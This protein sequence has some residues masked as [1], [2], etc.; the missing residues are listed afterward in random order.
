MAPQKPMSAL[1]PKTSADTIDLESESRG[2]AHSPAVA[3]LCCG[4]GGFSLAA[5]SLGMRIVVGIDIS[6]TAI[7]TFQ[8]NFPDA[9]AIVGSVRSSTVIAECKSLLQRHSPSGTP[10]L[11]VSGPPCQGFS[12]AGTRDPAD[13]RNQILIEVARAITEMR[14]RCGLVENVATLLS[15]KHRSRLAKFA[16]IVG[17]AGYYV[18]SI[19]LNA[20]D[21]GVPQ[22]RKRAFLLVTRR[23]LRSDDIA[24]R[25]EKLKQPMLPVKA[26]LSGLPDPIIRPDDYN[27]EREYGDLYNHL[28]MQH[29]VKVMDK[30][31]ALKPGTGPMSY[32]RLH[33]ERPSNTLFSGNRAPPAHFSES[34]SITVRE[35]AR[36]Q[37]F[38]DSF[39]VFGSFGNQM[40]QVTNAV[41]PPLARAVLQVLIDL[42]GVPVL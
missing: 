29:S 42:V 25:L 4:M 34:R 13:P 15:D 21:F 36:L 28:A 3:D 20:A 32:R 35:A 14:P 9:N 40:G 33:P 5:N 37:G 12:V 19:L 38:P 7:K 1:V 2:S 23:K 30:I 11:V 41:P 6:A 31:A 39:R 26:V 27:D 16:R 18:Q 22:R 24:A 8:R 10:F 17:E